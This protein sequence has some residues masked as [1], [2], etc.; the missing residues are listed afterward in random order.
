MEDDKSMIGSILFVSLMCKDFIVN[1]PAFTI[2]SDSSGNDNV[3]RD[4]IIKRINKLMTET[5][6]SKALQLAENKQHVLNSTDM[7]GDAREPNRQATAVNNTTPVS[8]LSSEEINILTRRLHPAGHIIDDNVYDFLDDD[9]N[10]EVIRNNVNRIQGLINSTI[11]FDADIV[12]VVK[13]L[14]PI[15][16]EGVD[17]WN[18]FHLKKLLLYNEKKHHGNGNGNHNVSILE[19]LHLLLKQFLNGSFAN[20][21]FWV[22]SRLIYFRKPNG[23]AR[24]LAI[25]SS[26]YRLIMKIIVNKISPATGTLLAPIQVGVSIKDGGS[27]LASQFMRMYD[28]DSSI[29]FLN[30]DLENAFNI[31]KRRRTARGIA[32]HCPVGLKLYQHLYNNNVISSLRGAN[33]KLL[34]VSETGVRQGDPGSMLWYCCSIQ[35]T[36]MNINQEC[37]AKLA[38]LLLTDSNNNNMNDDDET[39]NNHNMDNHRHPNANVLYV[40]GSYADDLTQAVNI[41]YANEIFLF[42]M[43]LFNRHGFIVNTNKCFVLVNRQHQN[44]QELLARYFPD[45]SY[46]KFQAKILGIMIGD[47]NDKQRFYSTIKNEIHRLALL[48][49]SLPAY[50]SFYL[51]KYCINAMPVYASRIYHPDIITNEAD[52][53]D[54]IITQSICHILQLQEIPVV[55][56]PFLSLPG[57]LAG[58]GLHRFNSFFSKILFDTLEQRVLKWCNDHGCDS[59]K[60]IIQNSLSNFDLF[61]LG[62]KDNVRNGSVSSNARLHI[63][64]TSIYDTMINDFTASNRFDFINHMQHN[65]FSGSGELFG[66]SYIRN[67]F[68]SNPAFLAE[69]IAHR[70]KIPIIPPPTEFMIP[71]PSEYNQALL[72]MVSCTH[73]DRL[74]KTYHPLSYNFEHAL[75]CGVSSHDIISRHNNISDACQK[76]VKSTIVGE[77]VTIDLGT[78]ANTAGDQ[79]QTCDFVV[80]RNGRAT[81]FDVKVCYYD[82]D[83]FH[84]HTNNIAPINCIINTENDKR[85]HYQRN[86]NSPG[87]VI[88]LVVSSSGFYLGPSFIAFC[89]AVESKDGSINFDYGA[90]DGV[91]FERKAHASRRRLISEIIRFSYVFIAKARIRARQQLYYKFPIFL[92]PPSPQE[93]AARLMMQGDIFNGNGVM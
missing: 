88:P 24:P 51:I 47:D 38:E 12:N 20:P 73:C 52:N 86:N 11:I 63:R 59:I 43:E 3:D 29:A 19:E 18:Y 45:D 17:S 27:I 6:F 56:L 89:N 30:Y 60:R 14:N 50:I 53:I 79:G 25:G 48:M 91:K 33:G 9:E 74:G 39:S 28:A 90:I 40:Q 7:T 49:K 32:K 22:L 35:D 62:F 92:R 58:L 66:I 21:K 5:K 61:E 8:S 36:L 81:K 76:Y 78:S 54:N 57:K 44:N 41:K 1:T 84:N 34:G 83:A 46:V 85:A 72:P 13:S 80:N 67:S 93:V 75:V 15:S 10:D 4:R 31:E 77:N 71:P 65:T 55:S 70:L 26:L 87:D 2:R 23:G 42:T 64:Y 82:G 68:T 16:A 37:K 69:C